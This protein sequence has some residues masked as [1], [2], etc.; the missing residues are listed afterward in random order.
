LVNGKCICDSSSV[1]KGNA[2]Q[3]CAPGTFP[4]ATNNLC[5]NC[6]L[7]CA[8]CNNQRTCQVCNLNYIFD[9]SSLSCIQ[10]A[11]NTSSTVSITTGFPV[12]TPTAFVIDFSINSP[13]TLSSKT[14]QQL[15]SMI[16]IRYPSTQPKPYR[17]IYKQSPLLNKIRVTFDY[18]CLLPVSSFVVSFGFLE[19][20]IALNSTLN[21]TFSSTSAQINLNFPNE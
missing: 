6:I 21:V 11:G 15:A 5:S 4:D 2:C 8:S 7:N 20:S 9:F 12:I 3:K 13:A 17:T 1:K 14:A 19:S 16:N 18:R 10:V